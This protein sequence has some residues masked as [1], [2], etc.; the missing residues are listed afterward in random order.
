MSHTDDELLD[1]VDDAGNVIGQEKRSVVHANGMKNFRL[2]EVVLRNR[3]THELFIIR[4]SHEKQIAPGKFETYAEHVH[5]GEQD[6]VA[7]IRCLQ[8]E[9]GLD[10][11]ADHFSLLGSIT[12]QDNAWG[13]AAVFLAE[14][15]ENPH[16]GQDHTEG[17]WMRPVDIMRMLRENPKQFRSNVRVLFSKFA[18]NVFE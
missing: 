8:E 2:V 9:A 16:I 3:K 14:T 17:A 6:L 11:S 1:L 15:D 18:R 12:E 10:L 4:R 13:H 5:P 7:A